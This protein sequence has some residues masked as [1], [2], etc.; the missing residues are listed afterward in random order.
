MSSERTGKRCF[1]LVLVP[2]LLFATKWMFEA[3][4]DEAMLAG[5]RPA[6]VCVGGR[7]RAANAARR[8]ALLRLL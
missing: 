6:G 5:Q 7:G 1:P 3:S 8:A 4:K 2:C